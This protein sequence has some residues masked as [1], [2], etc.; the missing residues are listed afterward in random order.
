MKKLVLALLLAGLCLP[1]VAECP[2]EIPIL[3]FDRKGDNR[4]FKDETLIGYLSQYLNPEQQAF[5]LSLPGEILGSRGVAAGGETYRVSS[6]SALNGELTRLLYLGGKGGTLTVDMVAGSA[7][8][9]NSGHR[10]EITPTCFT[11]VPGTSGRGHWKRAGE[12]SQ[13]GS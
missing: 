11:Y 4:S 12:V 10:G 6:L 1:A 8:Y 9:M 2:E 5:Y 13:P 3:V 7:C